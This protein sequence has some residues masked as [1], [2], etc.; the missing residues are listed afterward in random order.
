M[1][2]QKINSDRL[3][4]FAMYLLQGSPK[5]EKILAELNL[6]SIEFP[7]PEEG[8]VPVLPY[9]IFEMVDAFP[10][11][12]YYDKDFSPICIHD[13]NAPDVIETVI[14]FF[15]ITDAMFAHLF[16]PG[17]Q[18]VNYFGGKQL[19]LKATSQEVA[20]NIMELILAEQF[21]KIN[22]PLTINLN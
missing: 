12:W 20:Q 15:E 3:K 18:D 4:Q 21:R 9:P 13:K 14:Y 17:E 2:K 16:C 1:Q 7:E 19:S 8:A 22:V 10:H 11:D 5:S 6:E